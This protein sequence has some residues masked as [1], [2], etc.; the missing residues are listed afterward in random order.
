MPQI[1]RDYSQTRHSEFAKFRANQL[2]GQQ[3]EVQE[4][5]QVETEVADAAEETEEVSE[6]QEIQARRFLKKLR[7]MF[8]LIL[9]WITYP[10][11]SYA[12]Y[13]T[14]WVVEQ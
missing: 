10:K 14:S 3:E 13:P 4:Q 5:P 11:T 8:F 1:Q 9:I 2:M 12:N 7:Q 6:A